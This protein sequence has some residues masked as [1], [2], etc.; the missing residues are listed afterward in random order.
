MLV[1]KCECDS[2]GYEDIKE[3]GEEGEFKMTLLKSAKIGDLLYVPSCLLFPQRTG[4]WTRHNFSVA[5][6]TGLFRSKQTGAFIVE[7]EFYERFGYRHGD[8]IQKRRFY[9]ED[10]KKYDG[11]M[12]LKVD[13]EEW[14]AYITQTGCRIINDQ[15]FTAYDT[16]TMERFGINP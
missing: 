5:S 7:V 13:R 15:L 9:V 12:S 3:V 14:D 11:F 2:S 8:P 10:C 4:R 1:F 6:V 16:D